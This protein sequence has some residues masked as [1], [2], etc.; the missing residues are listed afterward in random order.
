MKHPSEFIRGTCQ[1]MLFSPTGDIEGALLKMKGEVLQVSI[2]PEQ[3]AALVA[4]TGP[5]RPLRVLATADH[6]PRTAQRA[7]PVYKF[8]AF[9]DVSGQAMDVPRVDPAHATLKGV[10]GA[11]HYARHGE[12]NG[13]LLETGEFIHLRPH[14]VQPLVWTLA[15][16]SL[17][18][19]SCA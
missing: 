3:G 16:R 7:H 11:W 12:P 10:V 4:M 5:G 6:S 18:W 8:V 9:A 1:Q 15:P 14:G 2:E 17:P 13:V 19:A